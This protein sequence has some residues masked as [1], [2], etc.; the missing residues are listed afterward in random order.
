MRTYQTVV[1]IKSDLDESQVDSVSE[2]IKQNISR[3]SGAIV[4]LENWGKKRLAYRVRKNRYGIYLNIF[5]TLE[6]SN[7]T[8][9]E[10]ELRL[11]E[12][13]LKFLVIRL[14][15]SKVE[16]IRRDE[17]TSLNE[18]PKLGGDEESAEVSNKELV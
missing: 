15:P 5:H 3:F 2:K 13:V 17:S 7:V 10:N 8:S 18:E 14:E 4:K 16:R 6:P 9:F 1:V 11:D 12:I